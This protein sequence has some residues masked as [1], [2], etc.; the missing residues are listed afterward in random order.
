MTKNQEKTAA[1][2]VE[3][4]HRLGF[5]IKKI[6]TYLVFCELIIV[7]ICSLIM[8]I[9]LHP[10]FILVFILAFLMC[11]LFIFSII[12][13]NEMTTKN[14]ET[15]EKPTAQGVDVQTMVSISEI[16]WN[17][18]KGKEIS[19]YDVG[20]ICKD[21]SGQIFLIGHCEEGSNYD[22]GC[23][24]CSSKYT[25]YDIVEWASLVLFKC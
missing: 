10:I 19:D 3:S 15:D 4:T 7:T 20:D 13:E 18:T 9:I 14:Q 17:P 6:I 1:L 24:C 21:S 12:K 25:E 22:G 2:D 5:D 23:G 11:V 16:K 8:S